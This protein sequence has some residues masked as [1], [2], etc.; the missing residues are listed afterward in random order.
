MFELLDND[1]L[2]APIVLKASR[3]RALIS[4]TQREWATGQVRR[5]PWDSR[6]HRWLCAFREHD[7]AGHLAARA[8]PVMEDAGALI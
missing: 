8:A 2:V 6:Q 7:P 5:G 4:D 3:S 1:G